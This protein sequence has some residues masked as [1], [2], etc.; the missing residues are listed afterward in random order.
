M[1][2]FNIAL[3]KFDRIEAAVHLGQMKDGSTFFDLPT[4][5][6]AEILS[7]YISENPEDASH[8]MEDISLKLIADVFS[9]ASAGHFEQMGRVIAYACASTPASADTLAKIY[10]RV[11]QYKAETKAENDALGYADSKVTDMRE[12]G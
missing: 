9:M 6:R 3:D 8:Y 10:Q 1:S 2:M 12:A 4:H 7:A 5:D 11:A